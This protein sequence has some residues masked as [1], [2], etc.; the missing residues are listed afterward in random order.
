MSIASR[1]EPFDRD[2]VFYDRETWEAMLHDELKANSGVA[3]SLALVLY[4]IIRELDQGKK[5]R[6]TNTLKLGVEWLYEYSEARSV[7]FKAYLYYLE[8]ML[9]SPFSVEAILKPAIEEAEESH[10]AID[11][12]KAEDT[13]T[14]RPKLKHKA[15]P[16]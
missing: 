1:F 8:G 4:R 11:H 2:N 3:D 9:L 14:K 13:K 15:R 10:Q 5:G 12:P 16:K 6:A 7:S